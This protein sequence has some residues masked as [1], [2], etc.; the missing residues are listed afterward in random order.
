M[1]LTLV[2]L[3]H[4]DL[5]ASP[6]HCDVE[7]VSFPPLQP[8]S[9]AAASRQR[10][11]TGSGSGSQPR[12]AG[13]PESLP[14]LGDWRLRNSA[15]GP[16]SDG[17]TSTYCSISSAPPICMSRIVPA[18]PFPI[19]RRR[20]FAPALKNSKQ[21]LARFRLGS[22]ASD[23]CRRLCSS[24]TSTV[25][26]SDA[27]ASGT[28]GRGFSYAPM[29]KA[30]WRRSAISKAK[31]RRL[32]SPTPR[33]SWAEPATTAT[34]SPRPRR[35]GPR[36]QALLPCRGNDRDSRDKQGRRRGPAPEERVVATAKPR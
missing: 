32:P 30:D 3:G 1:G 11:A 26:D 9:Y 23:G 12:V 18:R 28:R 5:L 2:A 21:C 13:W 6:R 7:V 20:N 8:H 14:E 19:A 36:S 27:M 15:P 24:A 35:Y 31:T 22:R 10:S 17:A 25:R 4:A 16:G 29:T 33:S 34:A